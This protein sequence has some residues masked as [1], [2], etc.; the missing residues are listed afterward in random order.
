M[1]VLQLTIPPSL[2]SLLFYHIKL[3]C[4][5]LPS[6]CFSYWLHQLFLQL[7][8]NNICKPEKRASGSDESHTAFQLS[9]HFKLFK[10]DFM[11]INWKH[12]EQ[13]LWMTLIC[14]M[15]RNFWLIM[16]AHCTFLKKF[17]CLNCSNSYNNW[18]FVKFI[19]KEIQNRKSENFVTK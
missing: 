14:V 9:N 13:V 6:F 18:M 4:L 1:C 12:W 5:L 10:S 7:F 15:I 16:T 19:S 3:F 2:S 17:H 8:Y 11:V